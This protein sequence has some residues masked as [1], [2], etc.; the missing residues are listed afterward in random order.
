MPEKNRKII[1]E[2]NSEIRTK[3]VSEFDQIC[4]A[5]QM[6]RK[7]IADVVFA[8]I[9]KKLY[10]TKISPEKLN[11]ILKLEKKLK[12]EDTHNTDGF[13]AGPAKTYDLSR[14]D[15]KRRN[16][17]FYYCCNP[18]SSPHIDFGTW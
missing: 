17:V 3:I 4:E 2:V 9:L 13:C 14:A 18:G 15:K 5:T 1:D 12:L 7:W 11:E 10:K 8:T 6:R 16:M